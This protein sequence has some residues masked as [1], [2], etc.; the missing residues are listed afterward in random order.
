MFHI[1]FAVSN[2]VRHSL[3]F[4]T[5]FDIHFTF[6]R[7][8]TYTLPFQTVFDIYFSSI[9]GSTY[10]LLSYGVPH[11][12][13][14][15]KQGSTFTSVPYRVRHTLYRFKQ[16]LNTVLQFF[17][18]KKQFKFR[19]SSIHFFLPCSCHSDLNPTCTS[20]AEKNIK[21]SKGVVLKYFK[22]QRFPITVNVHGI[23]N[24]INE[25]DLNSS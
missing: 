18:H 2:R 23:I 19:R 24:K 13:Y 20:T 4:H 7:C 5:G 11:T 17:E 9:Q 1:H 14:R 3:Q 15:F 8:S 12:L 6:I 16:C 25:R 21:I 10:T 22:S